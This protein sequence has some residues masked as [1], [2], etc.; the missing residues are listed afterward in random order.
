ME[1]ISKEEIFIKNTLL[2]AERGTCTRAKVGCVI[3]AKDRIISTGYVG[4]LPG[5]DHCIDVGCKIDPVTKGC[6]RTIHAER[7]AIDFIMKESHFLK[8]LGLGNC[9]LYTTLS[10]CMNCAKYI[11]EVGI[12]YV[13]YITE[14]RDKS[15]IEFLLENNVKVIK[16]K[17]KIV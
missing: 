5:E 15:P 9:N 3:T 7:N 13:M 11:I 6:I 17:G 10:P 8:A 1:R 4:S 14:Y 16:Y 2:W 12:P